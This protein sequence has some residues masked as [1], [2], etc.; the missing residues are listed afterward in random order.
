MR[1]LSGFVLI[2]ALAGCMKA[3]VAQ[4]KAAPSFD[5]PDLAGGKGSLASLKG[6]VVVL[7]FWATWCGPCLA[8]IPD[9]IE[10]WKRNRPRGVEVVGVVLESGEPQEIEDFVREHRIPYRI[11]LGTE[12]VQE[13]FGATQGLPTTFVIDGQGMIREKILGATPDKFERLKKAVDKIVG[14]APERQAANGSAP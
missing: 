8:E 9:Y 2:L 7:D 4:A 6:K 3:P 5:L 14:S 12:E 10:F 11:L 1:A 13:A